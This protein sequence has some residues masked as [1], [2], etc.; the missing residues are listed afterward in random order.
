MPTLLLELQHLAKWPFLLHHILCWTWNFM[1]RG[2]FLPAEVTWFV[3]LCWVLLSRLL[4]F[5]LGFCARLVLFW[6]LFFRW[7]DR[8]GSCFILNEFGWLWPKLAFLLELPGL[9]QRSRWMSLNFIF[10]MKMSQTNSFSFS[11]AQPH[12]AA[13]P[14]S[15][16]KKVSRLSRSSCW[17]L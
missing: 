3:S 10:A 17:V 2:E 13:W 8:V 7:T 1:I 14:E 12:W 5:P 9:M 15:L 4:D 11:I 16:R 6:M